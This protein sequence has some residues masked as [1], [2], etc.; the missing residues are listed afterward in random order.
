MAP[1]IDVVFLLLI[2]FLLTSTFN[3]PQALDVIL[4]EAGQARPAVTETVTVSITESGAIAVDGVETTIDRLE[5]VVGELLATSDKRPV[6]LAADSRVEVQKL[7]TVMET[8]RA[9]G[10]ADLALAT[11][12]PAGPTP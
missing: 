4:P 12:Q 3:A 2:F 9:A 5:D 6:L 1:L 11:R 10:A 7:V 8:L